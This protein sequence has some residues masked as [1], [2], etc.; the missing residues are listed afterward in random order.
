[1]ARQLVAAG[2]LSYHYSTTALTMLRACQ[3]R[4]QLGGD[5]DRMLGLAVR[6]SALR[7]PYDL[8]TRPLPNSQP[9]PWLERKA[10]LAREFTDQRLPAAYPD[11]RELNAV[12]LSNIDA[13]Q[14]E[15]FPSLTR[16]PRSSSGRRPGRSRQSLYPEQLGI[17]THVIMAAFA[18]L[19]LQTA[20][21]GAERSK[22]SGFVKEFL[23]I[24]F[25]LVPPIDDPRQQEID[26]LPTD[27]DG[28]VWGMVAKAIPRMQDDER[29]RD[30]WQPVFDL[31]SP[32]HH[33]VERF[34]WY[35]F[36]DGLRAAVSPHAFATTWGAMLTRALNSP[37]WDPSTA[38]RDLDDMVFEL[39]GFDSRMHGLAQNTDFIELLGEMEPLFARAA[40]KWFAMPK[41]MTGF[42][43]FAVEPAA[44]NLV[45][46]GIMWLAAAVPSLDSY[47]WRY[48]LEDNLITF[49]RTCWERHGE[50]ISRSPDLHAAFLTLLTTVVSRGGHAAIALRDRVVASVAA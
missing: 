11:I 36:S 9:D 19:D 12:A 17:D 39:L 45:L 1:L 48:G 43:R 2:V 35:W 10:T 27:F 3:C 44:A 7:R 30:L 42:L 29:P 47:D 14:T 37:A 24:V 22:W 25:A 13:V 46:P 6:W 18:W 4:E 50:E 40:Q 38:R 33:W 26:G 34:F 28:W 23:A 32:A 15:Q 41:V 49:L 20:R 21:P 31:G 8:A 16:R 5:F